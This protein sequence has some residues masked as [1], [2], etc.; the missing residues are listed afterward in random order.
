VV[1]R[2]S[3]ELRDAVAGREDEIEERGHQPDQ[4][5][6]PVTTAKLLR[7]EAAHRARNVRG[8]APTPE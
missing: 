6:D 4:A 7:G 5:L 8:S 2:R 3:G 1:V